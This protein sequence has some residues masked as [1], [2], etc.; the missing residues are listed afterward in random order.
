MES[1]D[2]AGAVTAA[3]S[4]N[5]DYPSNTGGGGGLSQLPIVEIYEIHSTQARSAQARGAQAKR[6][7]RTND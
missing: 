1:A 3:D 7:L 6:A 4:D 5:T 2:D